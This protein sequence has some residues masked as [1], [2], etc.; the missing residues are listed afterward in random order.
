MHCRSAMGLA[1]MCES[2]ENVMVVFQTNKVVE[3]FEL[4]EDM[5]ELDLVKCLLFFSL[6]AESR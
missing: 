1:L 6:F 2:H 3:S 4:I 5:M